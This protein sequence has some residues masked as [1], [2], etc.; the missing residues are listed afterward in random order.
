M[1][2]PIIPLPIMPRQ[3]WIP[4]SFSIL[5]PR[6]MRSARSWE[7]SSATSL[8]SLEMVSGLALLW[9]AGADGALARAVEEAASHALDGLGLLDISLY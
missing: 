4:S 1:P 2:L 7:R 9:H 5:S 3:G 8:A 6:V